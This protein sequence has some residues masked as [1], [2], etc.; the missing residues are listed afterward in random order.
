MVL[1]NLSLQEESATASELE[2]GELKESLQDTQ[3]VGA[4]V[5]CCRTLDQVHTHSSPVFDFMCTCR[6]SWSNF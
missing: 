2:L 6:W 4:I 1:V 3:P 5:N